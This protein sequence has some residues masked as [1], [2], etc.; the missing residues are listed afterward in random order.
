MN[1]LRKILDWIKRWRRSRLLRKIAV[2][3]QPAL[4]PPDRQWFCLDLPDEAESHDAVTIQACWNAID[5]AIVKGPLPGNGCDKT[6]ERNGLIL[7]SNLLCNMLSERL[8]AAPKPADQ[9]EL[10]RGIAESFYPPQD[11]ELMSKAEI[12]HRRFEGRMMHRYGRGYLGAIY[13]DGIPTVMV[14]NP[15]QE[16]IVQVVD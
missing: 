1:W 10:W 13:G 5:R 4:Q 2:M 6:A 11:A 7:A 12:I 3:I 14:G 16:I 9:E 8:E 15:N